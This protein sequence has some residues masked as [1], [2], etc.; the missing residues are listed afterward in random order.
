MKFVFATHNAHKLK[1]VSLML[2]DKMNIL[3]LTDIGCM[4]E[5]PENQP[6]LEGN[7]LEKARFVKNNY[8]YN[9]FSDDT[10]L[11]VEALGGRPGVFS[12]RY[13]GESKSSQANMEKLLGELQ[14]VTNRKARFRTVIALIINNEEMVFEGI[15]EGEIIESPRGSEGFGYDP[16]FVPI[17]YNQTFAEMPLQLKNTISHRYK[18]FNMLAEYLMS[19]NYF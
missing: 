3:G 19:L 18:A 7:A 4:E 17:G 15:A 8:C 12:A 13:A 6:T 1:E 16:I 14:G 5:I 2:P 10:G 11:E 9:C